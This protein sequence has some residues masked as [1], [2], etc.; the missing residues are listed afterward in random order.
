MDASLLHCDG[1]DMFTATKAVC[2]GQHLV[3]VA[4]VCLVL[5]SL[6]LQVGLVLHLHGFGC[7]L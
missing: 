4:L 5:P 3:A 6:V 7:N 1:M 2:D